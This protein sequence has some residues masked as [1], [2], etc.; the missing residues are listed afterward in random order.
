M[1]QM[2]RLVCTLL[3]LVFLFLPS[4]TNASEDWVIDNFQSEIQIREDGRV[5]VAETIDVD[6]N[7]LSKHGI[8][9]DT[10]FV[11]QGEDGKKIYTKIAVGPITA[12]GSFVPFGISRNGDFTRIKIGDPDKTVSGKH[13]YEINYSVSGVLRSFE[14]QDEFF[15]N[16]TGNGWPVPILQSSARVILPQEGIEKVIC[17]EGV[18]GSRRPCL[19][20]LVSSKEAFFQSSQRLEV[21]EG[22]SIVVG[23]RK[24]LVPIL[25]VEPPKRI[26]DEIL[27]GIFK[28]T[29]LFAFCLSLILGIIF[30]FWLWWGR[31]RDFWQKQRYAFDTQTEVEVKPVDGHETIVVEF[32]PP[33]N[34]RP[35]E[36]GTLA[37]ERADT[38]DVS[39]TIVDLA[40]RGFLMIS[41]EEKKWLFGKKDYI[42]T[43]KEKD[44]SGLLNYEREL[45]EKIFEDGEIVNLSSLKSEFYTHLKEVKKKLYE[46]MM[47]KGF[48]VENPEKVRNKYLIFG[49]LAVIIGGVTVFLGVSLVSGSIL[50]FGAG[51][52]ANG[53]VLAIFSRLMPR[54]TSLGR[55]IY[56]RVRGFELFISTAEKYRQQFF[57]R[58]NLFNEILPYAIIF[59]LTEK[60]I[61]AF[62]ELGIEPQTPAWY[63][64]TSAFNVQAFSSDINS[65][66]SSLSSAIAATPGGSGFSSGGGFSGGGFGGGGGGSW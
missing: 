26:E 17:Y 29:S 61:N 49:I 36:V 4:H 57:E 56:R 48:F 51:L 58:K 25:T 18:Y 40:S 54:R 37:D 19:S 64:G 11:Y 9:R 27:D 24:G 63:I 12:D 55:E 39:A 1:V 22:L 45:L 21:N 34:L 47:Q 32:T 38:L 53:L 3:T 5:V 62:K 28:P 59:G 41:E 66:S 23:Y 16:V 65:F 50:S 6:F 10:P 31:G 8:Y 42:L 60:F 2:R 14:D 13:K 52:T 33:E 15:W 20:N 44:A 7:T 30:V 46:E 43:K 35:A